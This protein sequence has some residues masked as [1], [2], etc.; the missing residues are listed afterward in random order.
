VPLDN[1]NKHLKARD[2]GRRDR[3]LFDMIRKDDER[4]FE[5]LFRAYYQDLCGYV[6]RFVH[7]IDLAEGV[8]QDVFVKIWEKRHTLEIHTS[9][10]SYLYRAAKNAS[11]NFINKSKM[12]V[13][14]NEEKLSDI[15]TPTELNL[16]TL[17]E[18]ELVEAIEK[19]IENLPERR[20]QIFILHRHE[21]LTY[22]EIAEVLDI[23]VNTVET[24][25][26]RALRT[27]RTNLAQYL[28]S[29]A[30]IGFIKDSMF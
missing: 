3:Y 6:M 8:V 4:A 27:I 10:K 29:L 9:L 14:I 2:V 12:E 19:A 26:I 20:K 25:I 1:D 24:Q 28:S 30:L 22:T 18:K 13:I 11:L 17:E 5:I 16:D 23:S 7:S 21:G 15:S